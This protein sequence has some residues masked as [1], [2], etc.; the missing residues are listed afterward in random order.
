MIHK[1][2]IIT[3]G[4]VQ[5][6]IHTTPYSTVEDAIFASNIKS[7]VKRVVS[8]GASTGGLAASQDTLSFVTDLFRD[9]PNEQ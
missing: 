8:I 7:P 3:A 4:E 5:S 6:P 9:D 2:G 1:A